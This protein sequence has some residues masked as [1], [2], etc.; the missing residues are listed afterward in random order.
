[1]QEVSSA[2]YI[3]RPALCGRIAFLSPTRDLMGAQPH[4][5]LRR[6]F[7]IALYLMSRYRDSVG[8][9]LSRHV[10]TAFGNR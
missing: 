7:G 3:S 1:M 5:V 10:H 4:T 2:A 6:L 9:R 8:C